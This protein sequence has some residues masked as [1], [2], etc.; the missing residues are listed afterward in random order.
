MITRNELSLFYCFLSK[1]ILRSL[2]PCFGIVSMC[3][4]CPYCLLCHSKPRLIE[5]YRSQITF[6]SMRKGEWTV[7]QLWGGRDMEQPM[8]PSLYT[9]SPTEAMPPHQWRMITNTI[10]KKEPVPKRNQCILADVQGEL[11]VIWFSS[12]CWIDLQRR[13][14]QTISSW[15]ICLVTAH[16]SLP[17][18]PR[19]LIHGKRSSSIC[20]MCGT[21]IVRIFSWYL[22]WIDHR[23][24]VPIFVRSID[25]FLSQS[26]RWTRSTTW[27]CQANQQCPSSLSC[28]L[29]VI[30]NALYDSDR[31]HSCLLMIIHAP[32]AT[33]SRQETINSGQQQE[34][35]QAQYTF[36]KCSLIS[37]QIWLQYIYSIYTSQS[38]RAFVNILRLVDILF[39]MTMYNSV[40]SFTCFVVVNSITLSCPNCLLHN[41]KIIYIIPPHTHTHSL[42][43]ELRFRTIYSEAL[44]NKLDFQ[45]CD[46]CCK[47]DSWYPT[48]LSNKASQS[49]LCKDI[50]NNQ[51]TV[52]SFARELKEVLVEDG[53]IPK[54]ADDSNYVNLNDHWREHYYNIFH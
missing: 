8:S 38:L 2:L 32:T 43:W 12:S 26:P 24:T 1:S 44:V 23:I 11:V 37:K 50:W 16:H 19:R 48:Q 46:D 15:F 17:W 3:L 51:K 36:C 54:T 47:N 53:I 21:E 30:G 6:P 40:P 42:H 28:E 41:N 33:I 9:T 34:Q 31:M 22:C 10:V 39:L 20:R 18:F 49:Q 25:C 29:G 27:W 5:N 13:I 45:A 4:W 7:F 35:E 14:I 52:Y